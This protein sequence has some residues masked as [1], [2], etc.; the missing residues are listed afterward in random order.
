MQFWYTSA[1]DFFES[2]KAAAEEAQATELKLERMR[3]AEGL[4]G[5]SYTESTAHSREDVNGTDKVNTRIDFESRMNERLRDDLRLLDLADAVVYGKDVYGGLDALLGTSYADIVWL[6]YRKAL[7]WA[8][9]SRI[10]G[11]SVRSC[12]AYA[13]AAI[14]QLDAYGLDNVLQGLGIAED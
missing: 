2:V 14:N 6:R 8:T 10:S 12:Q 3:A 5:Q 13:Q 7:K 11:T 9:V 1:Q 4:K